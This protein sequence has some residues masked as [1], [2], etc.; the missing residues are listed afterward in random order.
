MLS[1][2]RDLELFEVDCGHLGD[3]KSDA[4]P[5]ATS[6]QAGGGHLQ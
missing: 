1:H 3:P 6:L 5:S 4:V 2:C